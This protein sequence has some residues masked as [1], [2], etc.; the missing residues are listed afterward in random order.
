MFKQKT[1]QQKAKN[2][3]SKNQSQSTNFWLY[4]KHPTFTVLRACSKLPFGKNSSPAFCDSPFIESDS[5]KCGGYELVSNF[6]SLQN[7]KTNEKNNSQSQ[8]KDFT[9]V[10][11]AKQR[12]VFQI[13]ATKNSVGELYGFFKNYELDHL[14]S[15]VEVVDNQKIESVLGCGKNLQAFVH[16]GLAINC[17]KLPIQNQRDLLE[18]LC[19]FDDSSKL[20]TLLLLDQISDPH[21][22]GAIIRS[23][24]SFGVK[25]IIFCEHNSVKESATIVKSSAG[26]IDFVDLV[27]VT[28][29]S[30]LIEKLKKLGYWCIGLDGL[31]KVEIGE[32]K[33]YK[34]IAL[35]VGSEGGGIR[36]LVKKN[37]DLLVKIKI[38][39]E[40]ES[41]NASVAA[42]IALYEL[43]KNCS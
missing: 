11:K 17:S 16:Q 37:C 8:A 43:S 5:K 39:E 1:N 41:L 3:N 10:F 42:A 21:N 18:E 12:K 25:K 13:L 36:D 28:N 14:R 34:N 29:F 4:G 2:K 30:N 24:I 35:V 40:V 9:Q 15:L 19:G 27:V 6:Q 38:N 26:T 22:V 20:P 7:K 33:D 23:A 32:I 31:A